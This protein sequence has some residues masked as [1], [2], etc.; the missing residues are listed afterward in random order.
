MAGAGD[1]TVEGSDGSGRKRWGS[2]ASLIQQGGQ[3]VE[4]G[5][6]EVKGMI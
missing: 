4:G 6:G 1:V 5:R 2:A 3:G